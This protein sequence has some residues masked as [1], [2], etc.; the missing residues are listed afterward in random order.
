LNGGIFAG[1]YCAGNDGAFEFLQNVLSEVFDLFPGKVVHIG[2]DEVS[3]DN[4]KKCPKCQERMRA[5]GLKSEHELQSYFIRRMEKFINSRGRNLIG[6]SEIREGGLAQNAAIMDWIGGGPEAA[7][8]GHD[9]VMSPTKFCY[10]DYYQSTNHTAEPH[11]IGGFVP[12]EK[13]YSFEP[14]PAGLDSKDQGH[15]LGGQCNLWT[16]YIASFKHV[17]Y[18]AFPRVCALAEVTWS[19][20]RARNYDDFIRRLQV[21]LVRL[22]Q[23]GVNYRKLG[24]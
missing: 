1:V 5:E 12:L 16:E 24:S 22:E 11:A 3:K 15:I 7:R 9:V 8:Q 4:W 20:Q 13:V 21:H 17:Q 18:M 14:M 6:W 10:L 2:G 19:P 23:A